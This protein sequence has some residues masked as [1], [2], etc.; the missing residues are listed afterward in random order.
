[1]LA[2]ESHF[3]HSR[4]GDLVTVRLTGSLPS[5]PCLTES[6]KGCNHKIQNPT[7]RN[8]ADR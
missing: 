4:A 3:G 6:I 8:G 7:V 1:M 2:D 5:T